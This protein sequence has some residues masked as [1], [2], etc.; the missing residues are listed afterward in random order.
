MPK[1][2]APEYGG[3]WSWEGELLPSTKLK[4]SNGVEIS[5]SSI[6]TQTNGDV[7]EWLDEQKIEK[8][9]AGKH[10]QSTHGHGSSEIKTMTTAQA[11]DFIIG[12]DYGNL[13]GDDRY[14]FAYQQLAKELGRGTN[15]PTAIDFNGTESNVSYRVFTSDFAFDAQSRALGQAKGTPEEKISMF[16][17]S[18]TPYMASGQNGFGLYVSPDLNYLD[19]WSRVDTAASR[20]EQKSKSLMLALKP[21]AKLLDMKNFESHNLV[22]MVDRALIGA[23]GNLNIKHPLNN[24]NN[25]D[26]WDRNTQLR[27]LVLFA[28]GYD[29]IVGLSE[30]SIFLNPDKVLVNAANL[31][32]LGITKNLE[33]HLSGQHDQSTHGRG[34]N[35]NDHNHYDPSAYKRNTSS[36]AAMDKVISDTHYLNEKGQKESASE[37]IDADTLEQSKY[38]GFNNPITGMDK[39]FEALDHDLGMLMQQRSVQVATT[40]E[41]LDAILDEGRLKNLTELDNAAQVKGSDYLAKRTAYENIAFGYDD[42]TLA[43]QRP[44]SGFIVPNRKMPSDIADGYGDVAIELKADVKTRTTFTIGDSLDNYAEPIQF[45]NRVPKTKEYASIAKDS[46]NYQQ[47]GETVLN[48]DWWHNGDYVEAQVHGGVKLKDIASITFYDSSP[49]SVASQTAKLDA[50]G[51]PYKFDTLDDDGSSEW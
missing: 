44:V 34:H 12:L 28:K 19:M 3:V 46:Y 49:A 5:L 47:K 29:G 4:L 1:L 2:L 26:M 38:G 23:T 45:G 18:D 35:A 16:L 32:K 10:D 41:A 14:R 36:K 9:L 31:K 13:Q 50:L 42:G 15:N 21:D 40:S 6:I 20:G 48:S 30:E 33:K 11:R 39:E 7:L 22:S 24:N 51:I 17:N 27:N 8:H 43:E 37:W 25:F